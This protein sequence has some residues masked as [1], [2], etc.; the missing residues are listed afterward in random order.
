M[1]HLLVKTNFLVSNRESGNS[2]LS[3]LAYALGGL[4]LSFIGVA[5]VLDPSN[6]QT[7]GFLVMLP[8][9]MAFLDFMAMQLRLNFTNLTECR[10]LDLFP[11]SRIRS[12]YIRFITFLTE[13]RLLFYALPL[14]TVLFI[15]FKKG[16]AAH[17][18]ATLLVFLFLYIIISEILF[19]VFPILRKL[20]DHFS[21]KTVIQASMLVLGLPLILLSRFYGP[22]GHITVPIIS[23][24]ASAMKAIAMSNMPAVFVPLSHLAIIALLLPVVFLSAGAAVS[25]LAL[26]VGHG[27]WRTYPARVASSKNQIMS[28][29]LRKRTDES[30]ASLPVLEQTRYKRERSVLHLSF[31]DI[32][33][34]QK[35]E[36]VFYMIPLY[37][38]LAIALMQI[39]SRRFHESAASPVLPI[40]FV[41]MMFGIALTENQFTQHG[42]RLS[43]ISIFPFSRAKIV[44]LKSFSTWSII[45]AV[46]VILCIIL[47]F[48]FHI[49]GLR[50]LHGIVYSVY[51]PLVLVILLN[52]FILQFNGLYRVAIISLFV[53]VIA[54]IFATVV[55]VLVML[56]SPLIGV[57]FVTGLFV[58]AYSLMIP[59]WGRR[60]SFEFQNLLEESK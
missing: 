7:A 32:R 24:F 52:T 22:N 59:W 30:A 21:A 55:Y 50:M 36:R 5:S 11:I 29:I 49:S 51:Q 25:K 6:K 17:L 46:N 23:D 53:I 44:Y 56:L 47:G 2:F 20:A 54:E 8:M 1:I 27:T 34:R 16:N 33:I 28:T 4:V 58:V 40:F 45:S 9:M 14:L 39:I 31:T 19:A 12:T 13:K 38:F 60:L 57:L 43:H 41:T 10:S 42:L 3:Y 35:E 26:R 18:F 15:L 37:P 48:K